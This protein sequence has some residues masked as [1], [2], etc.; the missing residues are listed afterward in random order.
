M[1]ATPASAARVILDA[2][3]P[4][5]KRIVAADANRRMVRLSR[6]EVSILAVVLPQWMHEIQATEDVRRSLRRARERR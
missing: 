2:I 6:D 4:I 3:A 5:A 1:T